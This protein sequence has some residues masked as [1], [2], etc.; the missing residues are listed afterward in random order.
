MSLDERSFIR[1]VLGMWLERVLG[2]WLGRPSK[3]EGT[4]GAKLEVKEHHKQRK[5]QIGSVVGCVSFLWLPKKL[6]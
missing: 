4:V 5:H 6:P 2:M 1:G 3:G